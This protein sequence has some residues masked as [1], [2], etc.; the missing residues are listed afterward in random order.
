MGLG[1]AA[2]VSLLEAFGLDPH[3]IAV[4]Q[5]FDAALARFR[6]GVLAV[7]ALRLVVRRVLDG[8]LVGRDVALEVAQDHLVVRV[9][10]Q[11][12]GHDRDLAAAARGVD[13]VCRHRV[14]AGVATQALH[15]LHA[16][17]DGRPEMARTLDQVALVDVVRPNP[18]LRQ[19]VDQ[20]PHDVDAVVDAGQQD[21]LVAQRDAGP[22][23]LVAGAGDFGR[24][25][26]GV[27]EVEVHPQR[28][29]LR[30]HLAQ[31]VVHALGHEDRHARADADDLHVRDLADAADHRFQE[32][33]GQGQAIAAADQDVADLWRPADV[34]ELSLVLGAVEVL[35]RVA[36]DPRPGAVAAVAG[37]LGR[38]QH[39]DTIR[40]A[41][42]QAR[43]GRVAVLGQRVAH[44]GREGLVL[45][46]GGDDLTA[47]RVVRVV[48]VDE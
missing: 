27:V 30:Q 9:A 15:D 8:L 10:E 41:V 39:Q 34:V 38:D 20:R 14:A 2:Q 24:D 5:A 3:L 35:G 1:S 25:L 45:A 36:H 12:V 16:L 46:G 43:H 17:A 4:E 22:G 28:V 48:G 6:P 21:R 23:E 29:V 31:L 44:H 32:P 37:A 13:H 47:D 42:H 18:N 33:G 26:V 7:P 11:V 19:P 40:V